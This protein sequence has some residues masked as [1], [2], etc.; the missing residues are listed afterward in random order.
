M[1]KRIVVLGGGESGV[2]AA[3]LAKKKGLK[4]FLSDKGEIKKENKEVLSNNRIKWEEGQHSEG[5]ILLADEIVKSPGIP[6]NVALLNKA[7]QAGIPIISE[8]EF[9]A[10]YTNGKLICITGSNGKTTTTLLISHLLQSGNLD[11]ATAG[12]VGKSFAGQLAESD[13]EYWVLELSSF[14]LDGM[15][16]FKADIAI[17]LNV[18]P[19]H[20]D[21][22]DYEFQNYVDSKFRI[23]QNMDEHDVFIYW[24]DDPVI[25][26]E[27]QKR[28]ISAQKFPFSENRENSN[29]TQGAYVENEQLIIINNNNKFSMRIHELA[30]QGR[31][32]L[33]NSMAS[34]MAA[35]TLELRKETVRESLANFTNVEHRLEYVAHVA[36]IKFINDSKATNINSTWYALESME[37]DVIWIAGGV[38]KGN[39]YTELYDLIKDRVKVLICLGENNEKLIKAFEGK[40]DEIVEAKNM[41]QAVNLG[42]QYGHKGDTVLLSPACASFD[43][44]E[45]Y[46]ERGRLFKTAVK[47]L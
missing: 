16:D 12:N 36:G 45:N 26:K 28:D 17:L 2:G 23:I 20:L 22:Y 11:V 24:A 31:H 18:T 1:A 25:Q 7:R 44:F 37:S 19:D 40:I 42:Y 3:V 6:D 32:N 29:E 39:D 41:H 5:E 38:D 27:L 46:E 9:A 47:A 15:Y 14:Q 43:L 33:N 21:R 34:G 13:H 8:I 4:V 10:R 30:L 35:R